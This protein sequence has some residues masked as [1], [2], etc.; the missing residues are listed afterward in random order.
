MVTL[1]S[2]SV[3]GVGGSVGSVQSIA[4]GGMLV[5]FTVVVPGGQVGMPVGEMVGIV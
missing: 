1:T 3:A 5:L 4:T 2:F